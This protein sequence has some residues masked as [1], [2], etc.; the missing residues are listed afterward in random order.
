MNEPL[1]SISLAAA[2]LAMLWANDRASPWAWLLPGGLIGL[3]VM[4]RP[5]AILFGLAFALIA[6]IHLARTRHRSAGLAAAGALLLAM[7]VV[8]LPWTIRNATTL[9]RSRTAATPIHRDLPARRRGHFK[10]FDRRSGGVDYGV[11]HRIS[12][13]CRPATSSA[14]CS[15]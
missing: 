7:A 10:T 11:R 15:S 8:L 4:F 14:T 12:T 6:L 13:T 2:V 1:S 9:T 5:E 3:T